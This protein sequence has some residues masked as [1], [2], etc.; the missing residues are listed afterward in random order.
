MDYLSYD[1][2]HFKDLFNHLAL[3]YPR[4]PELF[5][6]FFTMKTLHFSLTMAALLCT[7]FAF[8]QTEK[9]N[10]LL[11][12]TAGFDVQFEDPDN[13]ISI[14]LSPELGFFVIDNL[15]V[16]AALSI[17]TS[18]AGDF[19]TS[20]IGISP[21]GRYYFGSGMT[22]IFVHGQVGYVTAKVDFGGGDDSTANGTLFHFGPG[23]SF[24]LN[25]HVAVEGILGYTKQG[26][27]LDT[28]NFGIRFGVQAYLGGE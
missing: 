2:N 15:A 24:F 12:G 27:D 7:T 11:G 6:K 25:K 16:G 4:K 22:R 9:G 13:Y 26:G 14:D 8:S 18:K 21:F 20:A 23:V 28:S 10:L 1:F 3:Y 19:K 5:T 17:Q